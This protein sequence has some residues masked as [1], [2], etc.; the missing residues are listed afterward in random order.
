MAFIIEQD[1]LLHPSEVRLFGSDAVMT[2][3]DDIAGLI[4]EF[5]HVEDLQFPDNPKLVR[6]RQSISEVSCDAICL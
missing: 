3:A 1:V 5:R 6:D 2:N 4:E